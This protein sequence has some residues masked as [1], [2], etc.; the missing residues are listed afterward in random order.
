MSL[1][2]RLS[3]AATVVYIALGQMLVAR[4]KSSTALN[5][6]PESMASG[7]DVLVRSTVDHTMVLARLGQEQVT[8][9]RPEG[10]PT[11]CCRRAPSVSQ[12]LQLLKPDLDPFRVPKQGLLNLKDPPNNLH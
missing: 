4:V 10:G 9:G 3:T 7:C 2:Q 6:L 11:T 5:L 8:A 12:E 1:V